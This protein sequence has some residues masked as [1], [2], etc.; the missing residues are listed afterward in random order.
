MADRILSRVLTWGFCAL[1]LVVFGIGAALYFAFTSFVLGLIYAR[2]L[3]PGS[4]A[5]RQAQGLNEAECDLHLLPQDRLVAI[6]RAAIS[7]AVAWG[8]QHYA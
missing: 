3:R 4:E 1:C 7:L 6:G 5:K 2:Q 8:F